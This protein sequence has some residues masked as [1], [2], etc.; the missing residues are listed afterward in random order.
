[1]LTQLDGLDP[2]PM[3][4]QNADSTGLTQFPIQP[5]KFARSAG[6]PAG[7]NVRQYMG[8]YVHLSIYQHSAAVECTSRGSL[9]LASK[10]SKTHIINIYAV[11]LMCSKVCTSNFVSVPIIT[12]PYCINT[13][14]LYI[15][16][17]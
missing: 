12:I 5:A 10:T 14:K 9:K 16:R 11:V 3:Q 8:R 4:V 13:C 15:Y 2:N 6:P 1:M 17:M 7:Q